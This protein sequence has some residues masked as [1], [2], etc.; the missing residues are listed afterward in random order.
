MP[1]HPAAGDPSYVRWANGTIGAVRT[2]DPATGWFQV[3]SAGKTGWITGRYLT[4]VS[5]DPDPE[6]Q[7]D[8]ILTYAVGAW[9]LEHFHDGATRGF[10]ENTFGGPSYNSR[11]DADFERIARIITTQL[12][13]K[14]L[15]L[16]EING[17]S[18][19]KKSDELDRLLR[20]LGN[21]WAYELTA[22]GRSQRVA[23]LYDSS[24][25][26]KEKCVEIDVPPQQD[27]GKDVFERDPLA[28]LFVLLDA[29]GQDKNDLIVVGLH[30]ASGQQ[31]VNNHNTAMEVLRTRL[32]QALADG[33]FP[34]G[35][36]DI[37]IGGDLNAS[38]Y[39]NQVENFWEGYDNARFRFVTLAPADGTQYPGTRLAGVPLFPRSQIDYLMASGQTGGLVDELV[40]AVAHVHIELLASDFNDF[41][42]HVSDHIPVT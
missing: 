40:Q 15:I 29:A 17:R 22:A 1:I 6:P 10:P 8:E 20:F 36:R 35:E 37:L 28:C 18:G 30:L 7:E 26:R 11:T 19:T 13:A 32:H 21:N 9:N 3:E 14:I 2:I 31:L 27:N 38:R 24:T 41:R 42:Q 39:D 4:V 33:T 16:S 12:F 34:A 25:A 5:L 23:I